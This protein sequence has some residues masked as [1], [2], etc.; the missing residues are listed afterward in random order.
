MV[1]P[2]YTDILIPI[3]TSVDGSQH[4]LFMFDGISGNVAG[5]HGFSSGLGTSVVGVEINHPSVPYHDGLQAVITYFADVLVEST[6]TTTT[7][8]GS[9]GSYNNNTLIRLAG[10]SFGG[11]LSMMV[12]RALQLCGFVVSSVVMLD[13]GFR[14]FFSIC[15]NRDTHG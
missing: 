15:S 14:F 9:S 1:N 13:S 7:T 6:T 5:L 8:T 2:I 11:V 4:P 3:T 10:F 12:G